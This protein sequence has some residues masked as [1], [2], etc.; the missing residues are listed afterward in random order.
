MKSKTL[1]VTIMMILL[2]TTANA[3][4][5]TSARAVAMGGA[6]MGLAKGVYAPLYNP[7][8]IG[9]A[10]FRQSGLELAGV[11]V[12]IRNNSFTLQDYNQYTGA[13][14]TDNDKSVILGKIPDEGLQ[15]SAVAEAGA[16]SLSLGPFVFAFRGYAATETD[17]SKDIIELLFNG[18]QLNDNIS[19]NGMYS[20][21]V[22]YAS[23]GISYGRSVYKSGTR[24]LAVG[25][26]IK[27]IK[28]FAYEKITRITGD[29]VTLSTGFEG[30]G[31]MV[32]TTSTGGSGYGI[33]I[34]AALKFD[35]NYTAG[36]TFENLFSNIS[37]SN[38]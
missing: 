26:T 28:G 32:A 34:G 13:V 16:V 8:N 4:G 27:Y 2:I 18:N 19:L 15:L 35:D 9:L 23:G 36:I 31:S 1:H 24:Q 20:E 33:D 17:L 21:A 7:G 29:V 37:W 6:H 25:G 10:D 11:G 5:L 30:E 38:A 3:T 14:L 12:E 22:A